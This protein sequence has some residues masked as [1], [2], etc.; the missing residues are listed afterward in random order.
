MASGPLLQQQ[1]HPV[2]CELQLDDDPGDPSLS[3]ARGSTGAT[4]VQILNVLLTQG[5]ITPEILR[6]AH[7]LLL[8]TKQQQQRQSDA[9][10]GACSEEEEEE[11]ERRSG[12]RQW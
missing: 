6:S 1:L 7:H 5:H 10:T 9:A 2:L 3:S 8:L 4:A 11:E 12:C